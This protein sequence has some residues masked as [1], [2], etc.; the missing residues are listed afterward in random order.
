LNHQKM[1]NVSTIDTTYNSLT[2]V[3]V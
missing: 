1:P 2:S 3:I